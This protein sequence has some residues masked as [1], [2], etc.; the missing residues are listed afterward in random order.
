MRF[1]SDRT[2]AARGRW[3]RLPRAFALLLALL[4]LAPPALGADPGE[5]SWE[6]VLRRSSGEELL[7][8]A[9]GE[10]ARW[11]IAWR[12]SVSGSPVSDTFEWRDGTLYLV[13]HATLH[14]DIAGLGLTPGRGTLEEAPGGGFVIRNIFE[15]IHGNVHHFIIGSERTDMVLVHRDRSY[16]LS[17]HLPGVRA[18]IEVEGP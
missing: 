14:L 18:R 16:P 15:P 11:T 6:L 1:G 10:E 3:R 8:V 9:L 4:L 2:R 12:H 7:R 13:E 5:R 17:A